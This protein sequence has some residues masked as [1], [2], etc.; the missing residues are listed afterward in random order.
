MKPGGPAVRFAFADRLR[1]DA[2]AVIDGLKRE[3][4]EILLRSGDN[5]AAV[6]AVADALQIADRRS[7]QSPAD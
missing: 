2:R 5:A 4:L 6:D 3:G 1:T 7:A